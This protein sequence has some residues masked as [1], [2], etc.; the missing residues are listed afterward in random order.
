MTKANYVKVGRK[1]ADGKNPK[2]HYAFRVPQEIAARINEL[3]ETDQ[4]KNKTDLT[5]QAFEF[6]FKHLDSQ[7]VK[8]I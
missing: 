8:E 1:P 7:K 6:F 4:F 5:Q 2:V 3:S